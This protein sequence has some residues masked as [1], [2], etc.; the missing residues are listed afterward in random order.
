ME[1]HAHPHT[2]RKR[3]KHYLFEFFMLFLAVFCGFLAEN[4]REGLVTKE[5]ALHYM[6]NMVADLRTDIAAFDTATYYMQLWHDHLDT[7]LKIPIHRLRNVNSQ[8]T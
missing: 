1:V 2:E 3:L 7:A 6:E 5:K 4:F 8:D